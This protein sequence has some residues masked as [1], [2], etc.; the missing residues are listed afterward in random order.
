[1]AYK[2][3]LALTGIVVGFMVLGTTACGQHGKQR[4]ALEEQAARAQAKQQAQLQEEQR[5]EAEK[6]EKQREA[7][8]VRD[9]ISK[10]GDF[11]VCKTCTIKFH[12]ERDNMCFNEDLLTVNEWCS[13]WA[14]VLSRTGYVLFLDSRHTL[15]VPTTK[16]EQA[17][18]QGY[19]YQ[20]DSRYIVDFGA[21]QQVVS[22]R[23]WDLNLGCRELQQLD[24]VTPLLDGLKADFSWHWKLTDI[25]AASGRLSSERQ[26]GV[27]YFTNTANGLNID[28]I[29][30]E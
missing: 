13:F 29:R 20:S 2:R 30:M 1:M 14:E 11:A 10:N 15:W 9:A 3:G 26:R 22:G 17:L 28:K 5:A 24:A 16:G 19:I 7:A 12:N 6:T 8:L 25:G 27:A 18:G 21:V 23:K 4:K